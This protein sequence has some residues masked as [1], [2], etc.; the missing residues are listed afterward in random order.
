MAVPRA[1]GKRFATFLLLNRGLYF[2]NNTSLH[3][4]DM[5]SKTH[6]QWLAL[7]ERIRGLDWPSCPL[8][9][10]FFNLPKWVQQEMKNFGYKPIQDFPQ[11]FFPGGPNKLT[12]FYQQ[13]QDGGGTSF[14]QEYVEIIKSRYPGR[15]FNKCYEW[16][17]GPGFIGFG[18]MDHDLCKYLCLTDIH[19]PSLCCAE[20][21][22]NYPK[23]KCHDRVSTYLLKDLS[24]LPANEMFDLI[25][26]NPPHANGF[27]DE[28]CWTANTNRLTTDLNW[29]A[30]R[31]FFANIKSHL[32]P[33]G[34][35]LL[36]ENH[37]GS[38]VET[39]RPMI[40]RAGLTI[41]DTFISDKWYDTTDDATCWPK[42]KIYYIEI[43]HDN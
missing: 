1:C 10:D 19:D 12:V 32:T 20:E 15:V 9:V 38:T 40:E 13:G 24:L 6:V 16:C 31:N 14:G 3:T 17:S 30:H 26:A 25:V 11:K 8:E 37:A 21:T 5:L 41:T 23:N 39:F 33:N 7:Y 43:Q 42:V 29:E 22:Q 27:D 34:I 35:I 28:N 2:T 18:I 36:Q 4:Y